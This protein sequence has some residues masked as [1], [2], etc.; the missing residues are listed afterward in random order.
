MD[1]KPPAR[2][3]PGFCS[4]RCGLAVVMHL[5]NLALI[6]Q[7]VGLSIAIV[8][9]VNGTQRLAAPN[10]TVGADVHGDP[11]YDNSKVGDI[12]KRENVRKGTGE[13]V[14]AARSRC[15]SAGVGAFP[16]FEPLHGPA[17]Q[18]PGPSLS[19]VLRGAAGLRG[20]LPASPPHRVPALQSGVLSSLPFVAASSCTVLG[21]QLADFLLSRGLLRLITVRKLFKGRGHAPS[22]AVPV[23]GGAAGLRGLPASAPHRVP[24]LQSGVLS[25]LPFVAASSCTVLG[26]QLADFLLSRGLLR[27]ITVRKLFSA[28]GLLL[29]SLCAVALPFAAP[30]YAMT[31]TLLILIPGTSNLCDSGFIINTLDVAPRYASFLMGVSRG[32]G[33]VAGIMSATAT[34]FLISQDSVSGWRNVFFLS[35]AVN[36]FGLAFYLTFGQAEIQDWA[37]ERTLTRL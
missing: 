27:L 36:V 37:K 3:G 7:R 4:L 2:G 8:A 32:F 9:M 5:S 6:T 19:G 14:S 24:A 35:A 18:G 16:R 31:L 34:G 33:L 20:G 29:P 22:R 26:G 15:D 30:S 1:E 11:G 23:A 28:L 17:L 12:G 21:G 25:S 10:A 13:R